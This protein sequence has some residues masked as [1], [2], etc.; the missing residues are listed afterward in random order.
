M[1]Q[2]RDAATVAVASLFLAVPAWAA[3]EVQRSTGGKIIESLL[4]LAILFC[5]LYFILRRLNRRNQPYLDRSMV[6]MER[7]EK[8]NAEI[9]GLL[10]EMTGKPSTPGPG[11]GNDGTPPRL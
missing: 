4:S 2:I 1:R 11:P 9:I 8:Q 7:V 10:R 6:H 3:D 5:V